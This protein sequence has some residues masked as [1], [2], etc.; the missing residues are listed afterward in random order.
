MVGNFDSDFY[1]INGMVLE[2]RKRREHLTQEDLQKNKA[3]VESF[4]KGSAQA[5]ESETE[6]SLAN[7]KKT[8]WLWHLSIFKGS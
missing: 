3:L 7:L 1:H 8:L 2:S 5:L 6:V 4:T